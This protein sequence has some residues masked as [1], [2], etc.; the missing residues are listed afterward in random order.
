VK[1]TTLWNRK[2]FTIFNLMQLLHMLFGPQYTEL[3]TI[4]QLLLYLPHLR[5]AATLREEVSWDHSV[6]TI[7]EMD[8]L[9]DLNYW[10]VC[11]VL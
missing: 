6:Y 5:T 11:G 7:N 10:S 1:E 8:S 2:I 9:C 4:Q 3:I